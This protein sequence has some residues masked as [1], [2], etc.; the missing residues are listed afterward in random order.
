VAWIGVT[1][2]GHDGIVLQGEQGVAAAAFGALSQKRT[3][4]GVRLV[5]TNSSEP[6]VLKFHAQSVASRGG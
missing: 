2:K 6:A 4:Q 1:P 5:V 3:L